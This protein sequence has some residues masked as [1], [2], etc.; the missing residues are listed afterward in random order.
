MMFLSV[1]ILFLPLTFAETKIF[2]GNVITDTG[3]V[4][5]GGTF[6]FTYDENANKVFVQTPSTGLIVENG[7]CKS[8]N[9]FRVCINRANFSHKNITTYV[10]YYELNVD[11]YKLT[12]SL[13][14]ASKVA[15]STLLQGEATDITITL[16]NPTDF[17]ITDILF[18]YNL[19]NFTIKEAK[20]CTLDNSKM[21]WQGSLQPK[22]DKTCTATIIA[23]REGK[24][25][26]AGNLSYFN[27]FEKEQKNIDALAVTVLPK[28]LKVTQLIDKSIELQQPF[29]INL[30]LHNMHQSEDIE[31]Y[32]TI[33]LPSHISLIKDKP[34]F[35]KEGRV[36][37]QSL[38][39]KHGNIANYSLYL[40]AGSYG[41]E[42]ISYRYFYLVKG[43]SDA[44]E[45]STFVDIAGF[46]PLI[47]SSEPKI[48]EPNATSNETAVQEPLQS[49]QAADTNKTT[50]AVAENKTAE[51][52]A[53]A[54]IEKKTLSEKLSSRFS[55]NEVLL[56]AGAA[57][58][59][60][61]IIFSVIKI[62]KREQP[63]KEDQAALKEIQQTVLKVEQPQAQDTGQPL[64]EEA[65]QPPE[66]Q[67]N[68]N[69]IKGKRQIKKASRERH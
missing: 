32:I 16:T 54:E 36:M 48:Q 41:Q 25:S 23:E 65:K 50:A 9:V 62:R 5:D 31:A 3:K 4:V 6:R 2:S 34:A 55:R 38:I 44:I 11:I 59:V 1:L 64:K 19:I 43:I 57:V 40:E 56:L 61:L 35:N 67:E 18:N 22:Y 66:Q 39:L 24:Y 58:V 27:G 8:N 37:K 42:T 33:T 51:K 12:G 63:V 15:L 17:E 21:T 20:G 47:K 26:L 30:S 52:A 69:K 60:F 28:Q 46:K 49:P 13:S 45:N 10:Y 53:I 29:Y 7:A 68:Y 14:A